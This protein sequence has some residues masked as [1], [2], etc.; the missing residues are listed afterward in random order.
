MKGLTESSGGS[1][2]FFVSFQIAMLQDEL[3]QLTLT[4]LDKRGDRQEAEVVSGL[5]WSL[6]LTSGNTY[7]GILY[8]R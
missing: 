1:A 5:Q 6:P 8:F 2:G 3:V 4:E 7:F